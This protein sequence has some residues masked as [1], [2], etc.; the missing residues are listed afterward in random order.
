MIYLAVLLPALVTF[1]LWILWDAKRRDRWP[2]PTPRPYTCTDCWRTYQS[3]ELLRLH[4][5]GEHTDG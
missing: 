3:R 2:E 4:R 5:E 1:A